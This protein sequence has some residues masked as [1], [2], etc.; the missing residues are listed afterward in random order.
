MERN[1]LWLVRKILDIITNGLIPIV[2]MCSMII[3]FWGIANYV[4]QADTAA[5]RAKGRKFMMYGLIGLF[6]G[7]TVWSIE[8]L[9]LEL[10]G[11][12][13]VIPQIG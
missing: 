6:I 5:A 8:A 1:Y 9:F 7:F 12:P 2:A 10:I 3:F 13:A 4:L 11:V